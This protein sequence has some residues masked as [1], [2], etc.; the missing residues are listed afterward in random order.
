VNFFKEA[1][2]VEDP[3]SSLCFLHVFKEYWRKLRNQNSRAAK[4]VS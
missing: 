3:K 4:K 1:R 2:V